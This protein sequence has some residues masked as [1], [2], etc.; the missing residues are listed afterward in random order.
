AAL[1]MKT[2]GATPTLTLSVDPAKPTTKDKVTI[3]PAVASG[4]GS[5]S[6]LEIA[7][8]DDSDGTW[9][10][11]YAAPAPRTITS[12]TPVTRPFKVRVRNGA[13]HIAE[14]VTWVT[15]AKAPP[16]PADGGGCGC[17]TTGDGSPAAALAVVA[18]AI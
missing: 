11:A 8:D 10:V 16:A 13:G 1:G 2:S 6:G 18:L 14:A 5:A 17:R 15:F 4:D 3:T 9:D 7:W 12:D